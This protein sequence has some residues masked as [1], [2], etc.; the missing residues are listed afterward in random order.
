MLNHLDL[1]LTCYKKKARQTLN[2]RYLLI[3]SSTADKPRPFTYSKVFFII[4]TVW[5]AAVDEPTMLS[6]GAGILL[7][8]FTAIPRGR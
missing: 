2:T 4:R 1:E 5:L 8:I 7:R 3:G 6:S